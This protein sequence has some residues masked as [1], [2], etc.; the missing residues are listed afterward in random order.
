VLFA[1]SSTH[2]R[3]PHASNPQNTS[4]GPSTT[5]CDA[6]NVRRPQNPHGRP[7]GRAGSHC[8][9]SGAQAYDLIDGWAAVAVSD[10]QASNEEDLTFKEGDAIDVEIK[11]DNG[12][13]IG[14]HEATQTTGLFPEG[15][16]EV[17]G[18][19]KLKVPSDPQ[20]W[21]WGAISKDEA[22]KKL[23]THDNGTF[24]VRASASTPGSF[25]I[26]VVQEGAVRHVKILNMGQEKFA[27]NKNDEPCNSIV[28]LIKQKMMEKL[29]T[30]LHATGAK[31]AEESQLLVAPLV[32]PAR[33]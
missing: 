19:K 15:Y 30:T 10:Y 25:T 21:N 23:S 11:N 27:I 22:M 3:A 5:T 24:L 17:K 18:P 2:S 12:W 14:V 32:N 9:M 33:Q 4:K 7:H 31:T 8:N 1:R 13:W 20:L 6:K 16:V 28:Q 26:S 29:T